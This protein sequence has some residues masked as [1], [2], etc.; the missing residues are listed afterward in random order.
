[1]LQSRNVG[2]IGV[3]PQFIYNCVALATHDV[4]ENNVETHKVF[5]SYNLLP[6]MLIYD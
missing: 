5:R 2:K 3:M 4:K 1:M 6:L